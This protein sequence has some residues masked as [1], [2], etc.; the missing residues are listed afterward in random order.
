MTDPTYPPLDTLKPVADNLWIVDSGPIQASGLSLPVRM[1]VIR[2][3]SGEMWLHSPTR[4]DPGLRD[5]IKAI[6]PIRHLVAPNVAHWTFLKQWQAHCP[7]AETSAAPNLRE[8]AQ[9][10]AAGVRLDHDLHEASPSDWSGE[11]EQTIVPGGFGFREVAFLHRPSRTLLLTDLIQNLEPEK[12]PL[13][14]RL[15]A[16]ATGGSGGTT[17]IYLRLALHARQADAAAAVRQMINWAPER[18]IITHGR[19]FERDGTRELKRA[20]AWLVG[21]GRST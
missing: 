14:T 9:V 12:L 16:A 8:R 15:F 3:G 5:E 2:L 4:F 13:G 6:G 17:P 21:S 19:I 10:K 18:V 20:M 7:Q 11:I 1:S